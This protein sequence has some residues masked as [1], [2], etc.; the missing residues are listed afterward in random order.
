MIALDSVDF[1]ALASG[2]D[3]LGALFDALDGKYASLD[4][5]GCTGTSIPDIATTTANNRQDKDKLVSITLPDS[6]T[7]R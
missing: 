2:S 1:S 5:S 3:P 6:I 7:S 4:L